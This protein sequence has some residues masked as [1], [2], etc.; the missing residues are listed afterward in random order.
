MF[1]AFLNG[2][3]TGLLL[4]IAIGPIFFYILN[5]S[6]QRTLVDGL[7]AVLAVVLVDYFYII[8]AIVGVGKLLEMKNF[9]VI[10][11]L[12]SALVL[13]VFGL[14][15]IFSSNKNVTMNI[16]N[17]KFTSDYLSSFLSTFLLTIS[18]PLTIVFWT[19]LF[20]TKAIENNY[21]KNQL[22]VFGFSAGL[23]TLIFLGVCVII[24]SLLK[25]S[26]SLNLVQNLNIIV[27]VLLIVYAI[28]RILKLYKSI[29]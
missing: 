9:K 6:I 23:A 19:S 16:T 26:T 10:F 17:S 18:S 3:S 5:I 2:I 25:T 24:L 4:Q 28:A 8:L 27:G 14:I 21:S 29:A 7:L 20:A 11:G 13:T 12:F 15:M 22:T 1:S